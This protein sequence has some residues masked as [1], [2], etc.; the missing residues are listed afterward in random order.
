MKKSNFVAMI[1][2]EFNMSRN[3]IKHYNIREFL[4]MDEWRWGWRGSYDE[5][6]SF[7]VD[8]SLNL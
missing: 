7:Y 1:L 3:G 5:T 2:D 6:T 4:L 8:S